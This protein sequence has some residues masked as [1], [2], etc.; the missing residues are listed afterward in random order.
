MEPT[1][2]TAIIS[3]PETA[4]EKFEQA[5]LSRRAALRKIGI[6]SGMALFGMFA[7]DDLARVAIKKMEQHKETRQ[8]AETV[9]K[10]FKTSGIVFAD[11]VSCTECNTTCTPDADNDCV[12]C[13]ETYCPAE[14]VEEDDP[15]TGLKKWIKKKLQKKVAKFNPCNGNDLYGQALLAS[16]GNALNGCEGKCKTCAADYAAK[17]AGARADYIENTCNDQCQAAQDKHTGNG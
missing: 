4:R 7:V 3:N 12:D 13:D 14:M 17:N 1:D 16:P 10:E 6:T 2:E 15:I 5:R 9:A 8:I 11:T